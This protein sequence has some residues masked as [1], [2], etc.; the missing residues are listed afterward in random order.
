VKLVIN[1]E[2]CTGCLLCVLACSFKHEKTFSL[3]NSRIRVESDEIKNVH[4]ISVCIQCETHPCVD[5]CPTNAFYYDDN[6]SIYKINEEICTGCGACVRAC[7]YDG[8]TINSTGKAI[9]CDLC[10]GNPVCVNYCIFPKA[11]TV[12]VNK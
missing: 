11:L 12:L 9:K 2:K 6:L 5:A 3:V 4:K 7:P 8:I 10:D 1:G